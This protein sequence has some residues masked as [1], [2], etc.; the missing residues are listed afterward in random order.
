MLVAT[1][2]G[3]ERHPTELARLRGARLVVAAETEQGTALGRD[4]GQDADR[5]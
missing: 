3:Q 2:H 4:Q 5:R 1:K